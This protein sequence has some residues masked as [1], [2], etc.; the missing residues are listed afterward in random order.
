MYIIPLNILSISFEYM[1]YSVPERDEWFQYFLYI[2][3]NH[4]MPFVPKYKNGYQKDS[5]YIVVQINP[6]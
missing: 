5:E 3:Y 2:R 4:G 1:G 6:G